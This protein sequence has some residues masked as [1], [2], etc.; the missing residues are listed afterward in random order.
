MVDTI[1][2]VSSIALT[3]VSSNFLV[4]PEDYYTGRRRMEHVMIVRLTAFSIKHC[5]AE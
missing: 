3:E 2:S 1:F 5:L 4:R